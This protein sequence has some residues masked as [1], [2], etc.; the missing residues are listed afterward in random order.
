MRD[1]KAGQPV[2]MGAWGDHMS[3][4]GLTRDLG[5]PAGDDGEHRV[6]RYAI[7]QTL[8]PVPDA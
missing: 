1:Q 3:Q 7:G 6:F 4:V 2:S 8:T 5:V